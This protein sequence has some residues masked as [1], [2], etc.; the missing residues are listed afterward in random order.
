MSCS[1]FSNLGIRFFLNLSRLYRVDCFKL[2]HKLP[3]FC[4]LSLHFFYIFDHLPLCP[5]YVEI[6]MLIFST[7]TIRPLKKDSKGH[8]VEWDLVYIYCVA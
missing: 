2:L 6:L 8:L 7:T 3:L 5:S 1:V 4:N